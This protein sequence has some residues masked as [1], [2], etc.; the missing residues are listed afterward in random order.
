MINNQHTRELE[1]DAIR[2]FWKNVD[3]YRM[4]KGMT[5]REVLPNNTSDGING[6]GNVTIR[7][8]VRVANRLDL[9]DHSLL[10]K[11]ALKD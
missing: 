2:L 6:T 4:Q 9:D 3:D 1:N 7:K 8:I 10:L 5:W 11:Q